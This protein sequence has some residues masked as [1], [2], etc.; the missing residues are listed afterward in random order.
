MLSRCTV[1][2]S[3][4][5]HP[6]GQ[7]TAVLE[8]T[9]QQAPC[10]GALLTACDAGCT[11]RRLRQ[12]HVAAAGSRCGR[13]GTGYTGRCS[14]RIPGGRSRARCRVRW[15]STLRTRPESRARSRDP[16]GGELGG[17]TQPDSSVVTCCKRTH[18]V[19]L[20]RVSRAWPAS[21]HCCWAQS[22]VPLRAPTSSRPLALLLLL[23]AA[24]L[25]PLPLFARRAGA[26]CCRMKVRCA[27]SWRCCWSHRS[28]SSLALLMVRAM[29]RR[30]CCGSQPVMGGMER[31]VAHHPAACRPCSGA[32]AGSGRPHVVRMG[33][34]W[35][36]LSRPRHYPVAADPAHHAD[37]ALGVAGQR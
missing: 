20:S 31:R 35:T 32:W 37:R 24:P 18:A 27:S 29:T 13:R 36:P 19:A 34:P 30:A 21:R 9:A 33:R 6:W 28:C 14:G 16:V 22:A 1:L 23:A 25:L 10:A 11:A 17:K 5:L 3:V 8:R 2:L 4:G 15:H 26:G 7:R 12:T